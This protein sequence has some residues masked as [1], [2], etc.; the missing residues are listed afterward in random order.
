MHLYIVRHGKAEDGV[1]FSRDEDRPLTARGIEQARFVADQVSM[2]PHP[3]ELIISSGYARAV[4][5][6]RIIHQSLR[7]RFELATV[8]EC[9]PAAS[10]VVDLIVGRASLSPSGQR[11]VSS[12]MLVGH[13]PQLG[14]LCTI[15]THGLAG[16]QMMLRT[17]EAV[18]LEVRPDDL[19]GTGRMTARIRLDEPCGVGLKG[20]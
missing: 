19:I 13:N 7:C 10:E 15:L 2:L 18:G 6:A 3:P 14:E 11:A 5:T 4:A 20:R 9:G 1:A 16:N 8:L 17:G 12:L